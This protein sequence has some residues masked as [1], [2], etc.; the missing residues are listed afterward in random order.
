M[1]VSSKHK[2][3]TLVELIAKAEE[4]QRPRLENGLTGQIERRKLP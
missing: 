3:K 4:E 1:A 2:K